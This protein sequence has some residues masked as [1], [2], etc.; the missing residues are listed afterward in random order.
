MK[1]IEF[2]VQVKVKTTPLM[3]HNCIHL[4][5]QTL[6]TLMTNYCMH[7]ILDIEHIKIN[8]AVSEGAQPRQGIGKVINPT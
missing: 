1:S 8:K 4:F 7:T 3:N 5:T 6:I 2:N